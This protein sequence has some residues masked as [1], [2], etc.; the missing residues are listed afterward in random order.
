[1]ILEIGSVLLLV[2]MTTV[3]SSSNADFYWPYPDHI[4]SP[5][6][7]CSR[8]GYFAHPRDCRWFYRC[9]GG[10]G[11]GS[12]RRFYFECDPNMIYISDMNKCGFVYVTSDLEASCS[13]HDDSVATNVISLGID[14]QENTES[15]QPAL[16]TLRPV[17]PTL[18]PPPSKPDLNLYNTAVVP[19]NSLHPFPTSESDDFLGNLIV[20][21]S[22]PASDGEENVCSIMI[23]SCSYRMMCMKAI[24]EVHHSIV[25][26]CEQA[27]Y[28]C[29]KAGGRELDLCLPGST[30]SPDQRYC[31]S[32]NN[33]CKNPIDYSYVNPPAPPRTSSTTAGPPAISVPEPDETTILPITTP[34]IPTTTTQPNYWFTTSSTTQSPTSVITSTLPPAT[35]FR[36]TISSWYFT[37]STPVFT[38]T[39]ISRP[40]PPPTISTTTRP[41]PKPPVGPPVVLPSSSTRPP[42]KP[43][44]VPISKPTISPNSWWVPYKPTTP[45]TTTSTTT[46]TITTPTVAVTG[47]P[48]TD[49]D[50]TTVHLALNQT[51]RC[52]KTKPRPM[53]SWMLDYFCSE[54]YLCSP[55]GHYKGLVVLCHEFLECRFVATGVWV[56]AKMQCPA[57]WLY[58]YS[59]NACARKPSDHEL[60]S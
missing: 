18:I 49:E 29:T 60:C 52:S 55:T 19:L 13:S 24:W 47:D 50:F 4:A 54:Y 58:S 30:Y 15:P 22:M 2:I 10:N 3:E 14:S 11:V 16:P 34:K 46:T 43:P 17:Y 21:Q 44:D 25:R 31:I 28:R 5:L 57:P 1:M 59:T 45:E 48:D 26:V 39:P 53:E 33:F 6:V 37:S 7:P 56:V 32:D 8:E 23:G 12:Y 20:P 36:P 40:Q 41:P 27:F 38:T 9:V 42:Y 51:V 35:A